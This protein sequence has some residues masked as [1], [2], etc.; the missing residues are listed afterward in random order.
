LLFF[1]HPIIKCDGV[2]IIGIIR[3]IKIRRGRRTSGKMMEDEE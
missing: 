3:I 2:C 1:S